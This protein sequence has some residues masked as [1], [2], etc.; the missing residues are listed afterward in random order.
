MFQETYHTVVGIHNYYL[1]LRTFRKVISPLTTI[2]PRS[3]KT[4]SVQIFGLQPLF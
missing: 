2:I 1:P 3:N 4:E